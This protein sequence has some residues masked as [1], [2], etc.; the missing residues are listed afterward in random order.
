MHIRI[1]KPDGDLKR[2]VWEFSLM[3]D[4]MSVIYFDLYAFQTRPSRRH[5]WKSQ[6]IFQRLSRRDSNMEA[7]VIPGSILTEM[8]Q[9]FKDK[10]DDIIIKD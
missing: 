9:Q 6:S 10:I 7:P 1:E 5:N 2:E 4:S 3:V 8:R